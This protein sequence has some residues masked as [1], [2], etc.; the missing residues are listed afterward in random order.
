MPPST[1]HPFLLPRDHHLTSLIVRRAHERVFHNGTKETLTEVRSGYWIVKGRSLVRKLIHHCTVCHRY[2][3]PHYQVP[4]PPPLPE[5]RVSE[6]P[7]F[8]FTEQQGVAMSLHLLCRQGSALRCGARHDH[9][10]VP[11]MF[12]EICAD[13]KGTPKTDHLQQWKNLEVCCQYTLQVILNQQEVLQY[14]SGQ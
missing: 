1:K 14:L 6:Q 9:H 12:E 4:P 11:Q 13:K 5:F 3:G 10:Y 8:T 2:E 7:P